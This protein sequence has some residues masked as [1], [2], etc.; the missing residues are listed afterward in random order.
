M[1]ADN[2]FKKVF[3][4][5][6]IFACIVYIFTFPEKIDE[7]MYRLESAECELSKLTTTRVKRL[8]EKLDR[9]QTEYRKLKDAQAPSMSLSVEEVQMRDAEQ[10]FTD[11]L[12]TVATNPKLQN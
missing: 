2:S 5:A 7:P 9:V 12:L 8:K 11:Q 6:G 4:I 10:Y 1:K 3:H